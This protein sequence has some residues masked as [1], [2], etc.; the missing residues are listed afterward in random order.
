MRIYLRVGDKVQHLKQKAWGIGEVIEERHSTIAGGICL[1]RVIFEDGIERSFINDL[2]NE[3]CCL[4]SGL[5]YA[6]SDLMT[7]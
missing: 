3:L 2:E 1:V 7:L 4:Y 5:R 6:G